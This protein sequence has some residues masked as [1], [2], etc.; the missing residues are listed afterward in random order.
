MT[1]GGLLAAGDAAGVGTAYYPA[2]G[3]AGAHLA[4]RACPQSTPCAALPRPAP[5]YPAVF[6]LSFPLLSSQLTAPPYACLPACLHAACRDPCGASAELST[7][8]FSDGKD[9][10][11]KFISNQYFGALVFAACVIGNVTSTAGAID[12]AAAAAAAVPIVG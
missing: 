12:A 2:V 5:P 7:V 10:M 1:I 8:D 3:L 4:W 6:R 9:C 11:S